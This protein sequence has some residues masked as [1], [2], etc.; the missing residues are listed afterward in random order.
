MNP[1]T[2]EATATATETTLAPSAAPEP[3]TWGALAGVGGASA[4]V[5]TIS[6][7][8]AAAFDWQYPK[9]LP[10]LLALVIVV[11]ADFSVRR[12]D[13]AQALKNP[14]SWLLW[15]MNAC[16]VFMTAVGGTRLVAGSEPTASAET[17]ASA[18]IKASS[19]PA[20]RE[21]EH[22]VAPPESAPSSGSSVEP[23]V[24]SAAPAATES[25]VAPTRSTGTSRPTHA[26]PSPPPHATSV[27]EPSAHSTN[28][29]AS[30]PKPVKEA[31][32]A[33]ATHAAPLDAEKKSEQPNATA[34]PA[35][36]E[37]K[38][39]RRLGNISLF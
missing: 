11:V 3:F 25:A 9:W 18:D 26:L 35:K 16:L 19:A 27:A 24:S 32:P 15:T 21:T 22:T 7:T 36:P 17:G 1:I 2:S 12:K 6:G 37:A 28:A 10:L 30:P 38:G 23:S 33:T 14:L 31:P 20:P 39:F 4:A 34:A 8:L 5:T 13:R 29:S